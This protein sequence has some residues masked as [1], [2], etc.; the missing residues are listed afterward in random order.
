LRLVLFRSDSIQE[1]SRTMQW[2][3]KRNVS[4]WK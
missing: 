2:K 3:R 4:S 1:A